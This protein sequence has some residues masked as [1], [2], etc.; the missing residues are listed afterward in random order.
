MKASIQSHR[1]TQA[2][3]VA[4]AAIAATCLGA[5]SAG[6]WINHEGSSADTASLTSAGAASVTITNPTPFP[7][8]C[9]VNFYTADVE[10]ELRAATARVNE[11]APGVVAGDIDAIVE[12]G[13]ALSALSPSQGEIVYGKNDVQ[14]AASTTGTVNFRI[15]GPVADRY[16]GSVYCDNYST[17]ATQDIDAAVVVATKTGGSDDDGS[18]G[19]IG[20]LIP[21]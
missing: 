2:I 6:A 16:V 19:S 5:G 11:L 17:A 13:G 14:V 21:S 7:I 8:R 1:R 10:P 20:S 3:V 18:W 9:S 12:W 15:D 4:A